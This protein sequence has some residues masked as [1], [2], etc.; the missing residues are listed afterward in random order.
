ML[1]E[2]RV[3][4]ELQLH[5][6]KDYILFTKAR[7]QNE[8][9]LGYLGEVFLFLRSINAKLSHIFSLLFLLC[10]GRQDFMG[11]LISL[12]WDIFYK[13]TLYCMFIRAGIVCLLTVQITTNVVH[14]IFNRQISLNSLGTTSRPGFDENHSRGRGF[15]SM[16]VNNLLY[17]VNK[18][19]SPHSSVS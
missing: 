19:E 7:F 5:F 15:L 14:R 3:I 4:F 6:I 10:L 11:F 2:N 9:L 1:I 13:N 16:C 17:N 18:Y 12:T 8:F